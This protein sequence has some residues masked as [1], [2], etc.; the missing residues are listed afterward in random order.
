MRSDKE[1]AESTTRPHEC[2]PS[3]AQHYNR[4][5]ELI[6]SRSYQKPVFWLNRSW[7]V[8]FIAVLLVAAVGAAL[9]WSQ[10]TPQL[11]TSGAPFVTD[12][13]EREDR[14]FHSSHGEADRD[15][16][17]AGNSRN[18][19]QRLHAEPPA[20]LTELF[21]VESAWSDVD[22]PAED[23][24][25]T[26]VSSEKI[27]KQ[28]NLLGQQLVESQA[29][30]TTQLAVV[31]TPDFSCGP[32]MPAKLE[33]VYRDQVLEVARG[34]IDRQS[35]Q[36]EKATYQRA[37]GLV[38]A[39]RELAAPFEDARDM[40]FKFKVFGVHRSASAVV[41][42]QYFALSGRTSTGVV[43][44][45]ATWI[46]RWTPVGQDAAPKLAWIGVED[47]EQV[48][49]HQAGPLFADCTASILGKNSCYEEQFLLGFNYWLERIQDRRYY[50]ILGTPGLAMGDVNGD[51]LDDL[52]V[53]QETG[54]PNRL[55]LHNAD[56]TAEDA[57]DSWGVDW[58]ENSRSALLVDLDND[59][60]QD[61]VVAMLGSLVVAVNEHQRRF[62]IRAVLPTNDDMM[63]LSAAD[64]DNDGDLDLYAC[65]YNQNNQVEDPSAH[66]VV[67]GIPG[68][69]YLVY[70][71]ETRGG[72]NNLL[73]NDIS[74]AAESGVSGNRPWRFTDVTKQ[75]GLEVNN[76][77]YSFASAWEDFDN[78]G[79]QDL[80]VANDFG[81]NCLYRNDDGQFLEVAT[82][83]GTEDRASG[84]SVAWGDYDRNG[85]MDLYV[86]NMFSAA[87]GRI[88]FQPR[89][90]SDAEETVRGRLQRFVKG[91]TLLRNLG[92]GRFKDTSNRASVT[93][94]RWGWSS[95]FVDLNNDGWEDLLATNGHVTTSDT[96]DL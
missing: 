12:K 88:T 95:L 22:N 71:D 65:A 1:D 63:S 73:R 69:T 2:Q 18:A 31:V 30:A 19:T 90:K 8:F 56:D 27:K 39:L 46:T 35:I 45:N 23:G 42:R 93:V 86:A 6:Q 94:G 54:L 7:G 20:E 9:Y 11:G 59:G 21:D 72:R 68:S 13:M 57:S 24:W 49:T 40:R 41:T 43:E 74:A 55:F 87:G 64:F 17:L 52:Y 92:E 32:L 29:I 10:W 62:R 33:E 16:R 91:N 82:A 50:I 80:Y 79:D 36:E 51:G 53:C 47:F 3:R 78:D 70:Y 34:V 5:P 48:R 76:N 14:P 37:D 75:L 25:D 84:M 44:Q 28:L 60:D 38:K 89:F 15:T 96:G 67:A 77:R 85:H 66:P 58:L 61:L 81:P 83:T 4:L 26:E